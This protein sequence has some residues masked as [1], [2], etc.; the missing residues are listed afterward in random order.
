MNIYIKHF[1]DLS[2]YELYAILKARVNVFVVEQ[3]CPYPELDD[4]DIE[5]YHIFIKEN[6][7]IVAYLRV[8]APGVSYKEASV[9]RVLTTKR[10]KGYGNLIM[11]E[12][13]KLINEKFGPVAIRIGA[14]LYA[15]GFYERFGFYQVSDEY[16]ED[17]IAHIEM[18]KE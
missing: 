4:K 6:H 2:P 1:K 18:M 11:N 16:L 8:L 10:D 17:G 9:G 14:Q 3:N 12:G 5:A 15:K 7:E 13:I